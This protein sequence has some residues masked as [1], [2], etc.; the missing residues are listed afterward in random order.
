MDIDRP[1]RKLSAILSADVKGYSRLMGDNELETVNTIEVYREIITEN[2]KSFRGRVVDSPGDNVLAEFD[3]A[4]DSVEA[5]VNIQKQLSKMNADLSSERKMEFRIGINIGDIIIKGHRIYGDA[6]NIAARIESIADPGGV[7]LS[8]NIYNQIKNKLSFG[9]EYIGEYNVKNISNPVKIYRILKEQKKTDD[10]KIIQNNL[11]TKPSIAVIPFV[12]MTGEPELSYLTDGIAEEI[13]ITLSKIPKVFVVAKDSSFHFKDSKVN[14]KEIRKK[15]G[16]RHVIEGSVRKSNDLLRI[17]V[18]VVDAESGV[19]LW[20]N[21]YD[22]KLDDLFSLQDE[23]AFKI[24]TALQ[25]KFSEGEQAQIYAKR[26]NNLNAFLKY[27][28]AR[29]ELWGIT[30]EGHYRAKQLAIE[31][32]EADDYYVDPYLL[33]AWVDIFAARMGWSDSREKSFQNSFSMVQKAASIDGNHPE[34]YILTGVFHL[35]DG[36]H[37]EAVENGQKAINYG[38]NNADVHAVF[39]H[40]LRFSGRFDDAIIMIRKAMRIQPYH[41]AWF[42]GELCMCLYY[43]NRHSEALEIAENFRTF[44]INRKETELLYWYY[45]ILAMNYIRLN[46]IGNANEAARN[47]LVE[48][49]SYSL[50]WDGDFGLYK[51][52]EHLEKQHGDLKKAGIP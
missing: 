21:R 14:F 1:I 16:V 47:A 52:K 42:L 32:I 12:N 4:M 39:C 29:Y 7:C 38:P 33:I 18:Q 10:T 40:I 3:S 37:D 20:A 41:P 15:L 27:L 6:V 2:I 46:Q 8:S 17:A 19:R 23:I 50:K 51:H 34:V 31:A 44:A 35:Y 49:P 45:T 26:T 11:P 36:R 30:K 22:R 28:Q 9:Y 24:L 5:S 13:I 25:V 48:F 43:L